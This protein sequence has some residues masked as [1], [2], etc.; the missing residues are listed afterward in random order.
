MR[1]FWA[2]LYYTDFFNAKFQK[3][4]KWAQ[5]HITAYLN[6]HTSK[7]C[8]ILSRMILHDIT[9]RFSIKWNFECIVRKWSLQAFKLLVSSKVFTYIPKVFSI[10]SRSFLL[11][12]GE[13]SASFPK[14]TITRTV[15][16]KAF[17]VLSC[18]QNIVAKKLLQPIDYLQQ[19]SKWTRFFQKGKRLP[20]IFKFHI[21]K[22][23]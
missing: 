6:C 13:H 5:R 7:F 1:F 9:L 14:E 17:R 12:S 4:R 20:V 21:M 10:A 23:Q 19:R 8:M 11:Q 22:K 3:S 18:I 2:F 15:F 16:A